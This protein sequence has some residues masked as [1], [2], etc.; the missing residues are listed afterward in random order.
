MSV[1]VGDSYA[2]PD[3]ECGCEIKVR[4]AS[5]SSVLDIETLTSEVPATDISLE[6]ARRTK[7]RFSVFF[8]LRG[9]TRSTAGNF[10]PS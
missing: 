1:N 10:F 2:C 8:A 9:S 3:P 7:S 6:L 4:T 5:R